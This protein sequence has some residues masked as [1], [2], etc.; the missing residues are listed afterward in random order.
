M[1]EKP[2]SSKQ[3]EQPDYLQLILTA[4][5]YD[6][7]IQTPLQHA[8][9]LSNR[10][11]NSILLKRE[12]LQPV[13]SFK[14]RGAYN[15]MY[16]LTP[17]EKA[18]GVIACSAGNHAQG[19]AFAA[20]KLG[21]DA[22]IVMP[23]PTPEIKWRNV[24]R[25]GG[26]VVL[27]GN[28]FDAAK[29]ECARLAS[30]RGLVNIPPY[31][32]PYVIAG[33]GTVALE[34]LKQHPLDKIDA[35]FCAIGGGGL[36]AGIA[37]YVKR[38]YPKIKVIGVETHDS[39]AMT[40]ALAKGHPCELPE[41]GLF[42]DGAAVRLVG[43]ETFRVCNELLDDMVQVT[44]D[45]I[46]AAIKDIFEDSRSI[47]EPAG[48]LGVA[49]AKKWLLQNKYE[50]KTVIAVTSGANMN[51]DR[52]RFV[53]ER[54]ELGEKREALITAIIPEEP[55]SFM[56]LYNSIYPRPI[57]EFIY[58]YSNPKEAYIFTSFTVVNR[59]QELSQIF[60]ELESMGMK[61]QDIS[62]NEMAKTHARYLIGGRS[63]VENERLYRF[64]FPERPGALKQF[65]TG[66]KSGWN[67]SLFHYRNFGADT[68]RVLVG[69]QV[70]PPEAEQFQEFLNNLKYPYVDESENPVYKQFLRM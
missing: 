25:L 24:K 9:N 49:G 5:V 28:D 51:F 30:E 68:G 55:G 23:T 50:N 32:D 7:A 27:H 47:V 20:K 4:P 40:E 29:V 39:F 56:K 69:I 63:G 46:C 15:R 67:V 6:V 64:E 11:G 66:L 26:N 36:A 57:T 31:D 65:L 14:I 19:V 18:R 10:L 61:G 37:A 34:M 59:K 12:D 42:A 43:T 8:V 3:P 60:G 33:Q 17:E 21:I 45:Q 52:L 2:D 1:T 22:T 70:P 48:A 62:D 16:H 13:F 53:A 38:V 41:V 54:A 35:I 58:R 44:N